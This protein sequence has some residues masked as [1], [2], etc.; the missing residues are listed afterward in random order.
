MQIEKKNEVYLILKDLE[1]STSQE[2]S[3]FFTFEVPGAKF[4][5][6]YRNRMWDGKIRLFSPGSGEIYVGLLPYIKKFCDRNN[7]DY[8]IGEG[9]EDDRDV[10]RE[11]VKGFVKSLKPKSKGKSLKI[12]DYQIDAVHHAIAR[13]RALLVSPTASGK[14]LI[15]YALVRYYHMMGLKTL[16]LVP[17]T[18]LVEQMYTDFEDYGWSSGTYCQKI[19]QG[20]D[21]KVT[22]DV[23]ISTWQS[24]YKMPK[25][26]FEQFGCIIGDEAH[27][28]K[29][30]S[31]TG[32]MTKLH[33]CK[34]R[35]GL[36]GTLDGTQTHQLVLEGLFGAVENI[37]TTKKL[38]DSKTL[39]DLKIK[40]IILKHPN[41]REKMAY[42][43]EL[44]Y[45]VGNENRNKFI[46]DL[47][48][49]IDGNTLC[50]F[51][52][53]EKH[54][55]ILYDQVK[56]AVK[57]RKVF[58]VYGGTNARTRED[59]R[60][61]V[62]KEKKSIIIASYGTFSTGINIR[63][64][65]NIVLASPSKSKIRVL[66][67]IGRGLRLSESKSS[68]LVFDIADDMTYKRVRNFTLIHFM[69]RINIYAEQQFVYEISKVNLK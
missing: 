2:L 44:Q 22:R 3:S 24:I 28:F 49:H 10:V 30:K 38:I 11:V 5:P 6:M 14:S 47:L 67:S 41:I 59:I 36:T 12:R 13:N 31:L 32:I 27:L 53:V 58:F 46:Q 29:A 55:Q 34:Y 50:L 43:E 39:A 4:M 68:I 8:I 51:Q 1:P 9:V 17:T 16:I 54:G 23:V 25:K 48:L 35:F 66:Q 37:I 33:Q 61:I 69:E 21:R 57:D 19:Y 40:C 26:Y 18:S 7:V 64:I 63:N 42:A 62:E 60:S 65:N 52:L 15:I 56:D 45:L 20:H